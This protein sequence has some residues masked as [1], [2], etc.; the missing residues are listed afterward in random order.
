[1]K[2]ALTL[3]EVLV[4][5]VLISIVITTILQIQQNNIHLL[6]KV[7]KSTVYNGYISLI[8][9]YDNKH[10]TDTKL[11]LDSEIKFGDDEIRKKLKEIKVYVKDTQLKDITL[12]K[13][14]YIN[15]AHIFQRS[16]KIE[17]KVVKNFYTFKLDID[18]NEK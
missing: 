4:S 5:I 16:Y 8:S 18:K 1:M 7:K 10:N 17:D 2:K 3:V 11:Y 15:V 13:N 14:D 12:P 9:T 6:K